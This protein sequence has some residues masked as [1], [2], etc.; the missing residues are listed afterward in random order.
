MNAKMLMNALRDK[1]Y[2]IQYPVVPTQVEA[3]NAFVNQDM[4]LMQP[5]T[6]VRISMNVKVVLEIW[7]LVILKYLEEPYCSPSWYGCKGETK[8][9][10]LD[11][12]LYT[13]FDCYNA[14]VTYPGCATFM[15][16]T[17]VV[18]SGIC[19]LYPA[20]CEADNSFAPYYP[21]YQPNVC[22]EPFSIIRK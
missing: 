10:R 6:N 15:L 7:S 1:L 21:M 18:E 17:G 4:V 3:M 13:V 20:G 14:C 16:S 2:A 19:S 11:D 12:K 8:L 22:D 5:L 9:T